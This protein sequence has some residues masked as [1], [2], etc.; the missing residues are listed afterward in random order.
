MKKVIF[1]KLFTDIIVFFY[2]MLIYFNFNSV[3][4][5]SSKFFDIVSEDGH[6]LLTYFSF[7]SLN[8]PKIL[9]N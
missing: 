9:I 5:S 4:T 2:N 6:S 8:I 3:D 7:T 1:D